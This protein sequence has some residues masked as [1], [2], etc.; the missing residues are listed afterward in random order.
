[1]ARPV[2][3]K[4]RRQSDPQLTGRIAGA[5]YQLKQ[6]RF[7]QPAMARR[8]VSA[9]ARRTAA[10]WAAQS[11]RRQAVPAKAERTALALVVDFA[12]DQ[13][14]SVAVPA[15]RR[16]DPGRRLA[17]AWVEA[18]KS[19]QAAR[20]PVR[21]ACF[22]MCRQSLASRSAETPVEKLGLSVG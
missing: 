13:S 20:R 6:A 11:G 19:A 12:K 15:V 21:S 3:K 4:R 22:A 17:P 16:I 7:G 5:L 1:M 2:L 8:S 9:T 10:A 18:D 14:F